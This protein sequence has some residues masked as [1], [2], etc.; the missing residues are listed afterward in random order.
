MKL[1]SFL[2]RSSPVVV[3]TAIFAGLVAGISNTGLLALINST[4]SKVNTSTTTLVWWFIVLCL[5]MLV[6]RT[7]S[8]L[9]LA[10]LSRWAVFDLRVKISRQILNAPLRHLEELGAPRLLATLTDDVLSISIALSNIPLL[11]M[12]LA[13]IVTCLIYLAWLSLPVFFG[14]LSFMVVGI[15]SY[16][17]PFVKGQRYLDLSRQ[18]WD[19][20]LKHISSLTDGAKE[21]KLNHRRSE[22]FLSESL[23]PAARAQGRDGYIGDATFAVAASWGQVLVFILVGILL[24]LLPTLRNVSDQTVIGYT[25]IILYMMM[26]LETIMN[27]LPVV[28]RANVA[29]KQVEALGLSLEEKSLEALIPASINQVNGYETL[30]LVN[31]RHSYYRED[32]ESDFQLGPI[33]LSFHPGELVF[34][35][36]GNGSGKTT[37]AKLLTGLY[38]PESGEIRLNGQTVTNEN[39]AGYRQLFSVVFTDFYLFESLLGIEVKELDTRSQ[40]YLRHLH[41]EHKVKV[42]DGI[43][44]T[45]NLSQGQRKRLALLT[46]YL[47][48]RP[49]YVFDEW[50]AD[51]DPLFKE[52]FYFQ[53]LPELKSRGKTILVISHDDRYYH[54]ADRLIKLDYGKVDYDKRVEQHSPILAGI[55]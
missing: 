55:S 3:S 32:K 11:C 14:V 22:A 49:F 10:Y 33:N 53:L 13:V 31:V 17:I 48:D 39:R 45:L 41:L 34:L 40:E 5:V 6:G 23:V 19:T 18:T 38:S 36:G 28:G 27:I 35:V 37:L 15:L 4:L 47:E 42:K 7:V 8:S 9:L 46:A 44:S 20:L 1:V 16:Q 54:I 29:M 21:L 51:Q 12:H 26:P 43:F 50:A 52:I 30:E 2:L 25:L 24:F